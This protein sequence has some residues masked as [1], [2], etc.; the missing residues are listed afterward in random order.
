[1]SDIKTG[2]KNTS[3]N[4]SPILKKEELENLEG[5][6]DEKK[7][8][9]QNSSTKTTPRKQGDLNLSNENLF[10]KEVFNISSTLLEKNDELTKKLDEKTK[11]ELL[12]KETK[13]LKLK[14]ELKKKDDELKRKD[15]EVTKVKEEL[16]NSQLS[17]EDD[18]EVGELA[19]NY[20]KRKETK[21]ENLTKNGV[22]EFIKS[23]INTLGNNLL[24]SPQELFDGFVKAAEQIVS[25]DPTDLTKVATEIAKSPLLTPVLA[26][27][28]LNPAKF[29]EFFLDKVQK[30][31]KQVDDDFKDEK[32]PDFSKKE[33]VVDKLIEVFADKM[34]DTLLGY[35]VTERDPSYKAVVNI[36]KFSKDYVGSI[37]L[38]S[39]TNE[40]TK[41][42]SER[43]VKDLTSYLGP[44]APLARMV[45]SFFNT[46]AGPFLP[47]TSWSGLLTGVTTT[48]GIYL[49]Y[50]K[51]SFLLDTI[52]TYSKKYS[53]N[54]VYGAFGI[55]GA[56]LGFT[57]EWSIYLVS[58]MLGKLF[59][60]KEKM[61]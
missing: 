6:F 47:K 41:D 1:M 23:K 51:P 37:F 24:K 53:E 45:T 26:K 48:A 9:S 39:L 61:A 15:D 40:T 20:I 50:S 54:V 58:L 8:E 4:I 35:D 5:I 27:L 34:L 42:L 38:P 59:G 56:G 25:K 31:L 36:L 10:S 32:K 52:T 60:N 22:H 16:N 30:D 14:D 17:V 19:K 12:K 7:V 57:G 46:V 28:D 29:A 18:E 33:Q 44:V 11:E 49:A 2:S 21:L 43:A 3:P 55:V 13:I